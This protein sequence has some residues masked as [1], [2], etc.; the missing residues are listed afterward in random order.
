MLQIFEGLLQANVLDLSCKI[1]RVFKN[2]A[3]VW[4]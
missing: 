3:A 1:L 2:D 4:F